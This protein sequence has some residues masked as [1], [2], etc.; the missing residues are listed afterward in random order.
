MHKTSEIFYND[1]LTIANRK[2]NIFFYLFDYVK[3][4]SYKFNYTT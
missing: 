3:G 2:K 4:I 1:N